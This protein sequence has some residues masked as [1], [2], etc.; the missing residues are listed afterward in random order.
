MLEREVEGRLKREVRKA[1]PEALCLKF[2]SPGCTGVP[3]RIV[4]LPGGHIVLVETKRPGKKE[5]RRQE[6]IQGRMRELGFDV[7]SAVNSGEKIEAVLS[8][9]R[10]VTESRGV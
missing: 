8:R 2:E 6:Y 1:V 3:D 9:I 5:R 4:F 7:F 10:E